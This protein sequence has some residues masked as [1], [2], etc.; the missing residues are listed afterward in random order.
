MLER[1]HLEI[2]REV[3]R[4]GSMTAAA[5]ALHLT[6]SALSHAMRKLEA[7]LGT[8][9]WL[10]EGRSLKL[11]PAGESLLE[12]ASRILPQMEHAEQGLQRLARGT[13]GTLRIGME[14]HP[15]YQWLLKVAADYMPRWPDVDVD[16]KQKFRFGGIGALLD[17]EIDLLVT[18]DPEKRAS[19]VFEP[20]FDYE[21][22]LVV[23]RTHPLAG[24]SWVK[25]EQLRDEVLI[26]YPV[27]LGRLDIYTH[28][29]NPAGVTP[30][31]HKVLESTD[32]MLQMVA[33]NRGVAALPRWLVTEHMS[34]V[35]IQHVR[36]GR[37]G[38]P[39]QIYLGMRAGDVD[40]EYLRAFVQVAREQHM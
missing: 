23:A 16:V 37:K 3:D 34:R 1:S 19:L 12:A 4:K 40:V 20:V 32:L 33:S 10:R 11:T 9:I 36:L 39:K 24:R 2:V 13:R 29:L 22:V 5:S 6:Q 26:T 17:R 27:E 8:A 25:P 21:Q 35:A 15:C 7:G 38:V 18:P 30:R 14:C 28:F 31:Q